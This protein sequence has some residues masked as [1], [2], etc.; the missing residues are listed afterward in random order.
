MQEN[1]VMT[2]AY[3]CAYV[4]PYRRWG[5]MRVVPR[6]PDWGRRI[7]PCFWATRAAKR[8]FDSVEVLNLRKNIKYLEIKRKNSKEHSLVFLVERRK[9][10]VTKFAFEDFIFVVGSAA[11]SVGTTLEFAAFRTRPNAKYS[12]ASAFWFF[13]LSTT[14]VFAAV[15]TDFPRKNTSMFISI[16]SL[17]R[18]KK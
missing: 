16:G 10:Q 2:L 15:R 18:K 8:L 3:T 5:R 9:V 6:Q 4:R 12:T 17:S 1:L 13:F 11:N 7:A 14:M